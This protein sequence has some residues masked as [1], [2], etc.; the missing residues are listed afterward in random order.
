MILIMTFAVG[1][2]GLNLQNK[3]RRVHI[4]ESPNNDA[5]A[6]QVVGRARRIGN[7][8]DTLYVY[9]Y[10]VRDTYDDGRVRRNMGRG[11]LR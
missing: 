4:L 1:A 5:T 3:C 2:T 11:Y 7:P 10:Y 6:C 8:Y 9:E